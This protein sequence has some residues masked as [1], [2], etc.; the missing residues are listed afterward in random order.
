M[1]K[2]DELIATLKK[3]NIPEE[4]IE[5]AVGFISQVVTGKYYTEMIASFEK[6]EIEEINKAENPE[7]ADKEIRMR[8]FAK[9]GKSVDDLRNQM[10]NYYSQE[11]LEDYL[12][13]KKLPKKTDSQN[14]INSTK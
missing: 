6:A 12:K 14:K 9:T 10:F 2:L 4:T 5:E 11:V 8:Y 7:Q 3:D 1:A 13:E